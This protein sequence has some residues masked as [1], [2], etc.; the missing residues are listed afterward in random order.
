[1]PAVVPRLSI[2]AGQMRIEA[3]F[4]KPFDAGQN[5]RNLEKT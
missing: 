3:A 4:F 5:V 2:P 1:M